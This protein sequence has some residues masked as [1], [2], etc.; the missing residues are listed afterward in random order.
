MDFH[1]SRT[2]PVFR[3][4]KAH[5]VIA[6]TGGNESFR[7]LPANTSISG[8]REGRTSQITGAKMPEG[9]ISESILNP[10]LTLPS[11]GIKK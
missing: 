6:G 8:I 7:L 11:N 1:A 10:G 2:V 9:D 3:A 4:M 5:G